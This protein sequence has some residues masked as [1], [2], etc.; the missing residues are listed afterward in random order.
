MA[1]SLSLAQ[2]RRIA[3]A[4]QGFTDARPSGAP[5]VRHLRRVLGRVG[6]L[7]VDSVNV[8][9]RAHYMPLFSRLGGY[10]T[11]LLDKAAWRAPRE[12]FE[13]WGHE[14]SLIPVGLHPYLRWRMDRARDHAWGGMKWAADNRPEL[15]ARVLDEVRKHGPMTAAEIEERVAGPAQAGALKVNW[16]WNWTDTKRALEWLFYAGEV[17]AAARNGAF[18]RLYDVPERVLP[19]AVL[20]E[21]T[22]SAREQHREL[23]RVAAT[24]LGV[25][26]EFDL[27]DYFRQPVEGARLAVADLVEEGTLREVAVEGW[28]HR[29]YLYEAAKLPRR[30]GA[31]ALISP[32][33]PLIWERNRT[34]R[35][36]GFRYRI[37][38]Y[39]PAAKRVHGY[40][41][42]PFLLGDALVARVDLKADRKAGVLRVPGAWSEPGRDP[43]EVAEAL[44]V[45]LRETAEWLGLSDIAPP[46]R[47]DLAD[48]LGDAL[49]A[50]PGSTAK[51]TGE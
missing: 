29:G 42:L 25:A 49:S 2:A 6:L 39:T 15:V 9:Q 26:T 20:N 17:T 35:H 8:L 47:G 36:F 37:E 51:V 10:R 3:L 4:A 45:A 50:A 41:V 30:V 7:Q 23:V 27:R 46:D 34:E 43:G 16:G 18:A 14:A 32:F 24:A 38:I 13:Y 28:R 19:T 1:D 48:A 21:P 22:L 44:A 33:D 31:A 5:D 40:Y 11:L 12:L